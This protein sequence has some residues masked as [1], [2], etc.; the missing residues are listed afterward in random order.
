MAATRRPGEESRTLLIVAAV[1]VINTE[2]YAALSARRLAEKVGLKRQ[3]VHYYFRTMNDLLLAVIRH[4]GEEGLA[5]FR[6]AFASADP[7]RVLWEMPA[8]SSATSFAFIAMARH[9]P[10]IRAEVTRYLE[11]FRDLQ[12]EAVACHLARHHTAIPLPPE[13]IVMILQSV[14]Q[15]LASEASLGVDR[16]H[17]IVRSAIE[18]LLLFG[19]SESTSDGF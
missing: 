9:S 11:A 14:S 19:G 6:K 17:E 1:E 2:G 16:G 8:D 5:R 12:V 7:L 18:K 13:A 3:I 4:Y 15:S 10:V